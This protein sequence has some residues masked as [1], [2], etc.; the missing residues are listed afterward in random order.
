MSAAKIARPSCCVAVL[1][2]VATLIEEAMVM[3][4]FFTQLESAAKLVKAFDD[5]LAVDQLWIDGKEVPV[6][7]GSFKKI[8]GS[9]IKIECQYQRPGEAAHTVEA[10][11]AK[12]PNNDT[13]TIDGN[14]RQVID[15][16]IKPDVDVSLGGISV[17]AEATLKF[18][19][20]GPTGGNRII[21][22]SSVK[23]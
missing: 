14:A 7:S 10:V 18:R 11:N 12:G 6:L 21:V 5:G 1:Y 23:V 3:P 2:S 15:V 20:A 9:S 17:E 19:D 22:V 8:A 13:I 4:S 16:A